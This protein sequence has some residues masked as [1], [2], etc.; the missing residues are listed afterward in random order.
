MSGDEKGFV[1]LHDALTKRIVDEY[2]ARRYVCPWCGDLLQA[3]PRTGDKVR[4]E[5]A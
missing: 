4:G 2:R 3:V 5:C 1:A